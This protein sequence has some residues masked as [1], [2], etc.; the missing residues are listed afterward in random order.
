MTEND[1]ATPGEPPGRQPVG[2]GSLVA[3]G[4]YRLVDGAGTTSGLQCWRGH[5]TVMNRT[6]ALAVA[7]RPAGDDGAFFHAL[8]VRTAS[9]AF[10]RVGSAARVFDVADDTARCVVVSEWTP[11]RSLHEVAGDRPDP[12]VAARTVLR[13]AEAVRTAHRQ[14][15]ILGLDDPV[16]IRVDESG[17]AVLAFPATLP[18]AD[19]TTDVAG[20]GAA[21]KCMLGDRGSAP[22]MRAL[23]DE[24]V[25]GSVRTAAVFAER[26]GRLLPGAPPDRPEPV[27]RIAAPVREPEPS[28]ATTARRSA[29]VP[30]V[31]ALVGVAC[32]AAVG[33]VAGTALSGPRA[34]S[35]APTTLPVIVAASPPT[36]GGTTVPVVPRAVRAHA[37]EGAADNAV[38][39]DLAVDGNPNTAW[40]TELYPRQ[41]PAGRAGLGLTVAF[42]QPVRLGEVWIDS[43]SAGTHVEIR[44]A[45]D[46]G[47]P[48]HLSQVVG[49]ATL[50][51]GIT[52][53]PVAATAAPMSE[54]LVWI[55]RLGPAGDRFRTSLSEVGFTTFDGP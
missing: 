37:Q 26:L 16:R 51:E 12:A 36:V 34:E 50:D 14:S 46:G 22:A 38:T 19:E 41:L 29:A 20:L 11:G 33:W 25:D 13:L 32:L 4:R 3:D 52:R 8:C 15:T 47:G 39:A 2:A 1:G 49:T 40:S 6:V 10:A 31:V 45:P 35:A 55:T 27:A 5:D 18:G 54:V 28:P 9:A 44:T 48:L 17:A 30:A 24:A 21:L 43:L 7:P 53:I 23:A 42:A